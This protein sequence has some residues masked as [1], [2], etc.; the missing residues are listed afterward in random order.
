MTTDVVRSAST[1]RS[2]SSRSRARGF[3]TRTCLPAAIA[4][5]ATSR[6]VPGG[7]QTM[8]AVTRG[9]ARRSFVLE[10]R[11]G[12]PYRSA[13]RVNVAGSESQA[14]TAAAVELRLRAGRWRSSAARPQPMMPTPSAGAV[15]PLIPRKPAEVA[16]RWGRVPGGRERCQPCETAYS[17]YGIRTRAAAVRGRCPRPL[18]EWAVRRG[19]VPNLAAI[20]HRRALRA[21]RPTAVRRP[22]RSLP[23]AAVDPRLEAAADLLARRR[24]AR[25]TGRG[26][27]GASRSGR[28]RRD[29]RDSVRTPPPHRAA[30]DARCSAEAMSS[31]DT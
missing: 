1:I 15:V 22:G 9:S 25:R 30:S 31:T 20:A 28:S 6:W 12:I 19:S 4:A 10:Y 8:I 3:L 23:V 11:L 27:G 24:A 16:S 17:P 13:T 29:R 7:V 2:T 5:S 26:V 14:A 18:D 21:E